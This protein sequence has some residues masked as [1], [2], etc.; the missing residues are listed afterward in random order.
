M[1]TTVK[2][3]VYPS[4][5]MNV[6]RWNQTIAANSDE[7]T[8]D[9]TVAAASEA[10]VEKAMK[11]WGQSMRSEVV[12]VPTEVPADYERLRVRYEI[13]G[14]YQ[15]AM[16]SAKPPNASWDRGENAW[17]RDGGFQITRHGRIQIDKGKFREVTF[18][19]WERL[20]LGLTQMHGSRMFLNRP[21][22]GFGV[23]AQIKGA[24]ARFA[25]H[26]L[27]THRVTQILQANPLNF[28][29]A[30]AAVDPTAAPQ[31]GVALIEGNVKTG[32]LDEIV[33]DTAADSTDVQMQKNM[34]NELLKLFWKDDDSH[35]IAKRLAMA[36]WLHSMLKQLGE[37]HKSDEERLISARL[38]ID[39]KHY[40]WYIGYA[41]KCLGV[42]RDVRLRGVHH[43]EKLDADACMPY[44][45]GDYEFYP[46]KGIATSPESR[47][48]DEGARALVKWWRVYSAMHRSMY[49]NNRDEFERIVKQLEK[50]PDEFKD[51][52]NMFRVTRSG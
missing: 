32:Q 25:R 35:T 38:L 45:P 17:G 30:W 49:E 3:A 14:L 2:V 18:N 48:T 44:G 39:A 50:S 51:L 7:T 4:L 9:S 34:A 24:I 31:A 15:K 42:R 12:Y 27:E 16:E 28:A 41:D 29:A 10:S 26:T 5:V 8:V 37:G 11:M 46:A 36:G 1:R 23:L 20:R 6:W 43:A 33:V 52:S 21:L 13:R 19:L 40:H 22:R 47:I